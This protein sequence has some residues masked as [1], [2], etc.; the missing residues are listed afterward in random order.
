MSEPVSSRVL[1]T[2]SDPNREFHFFRSLGILSLSWRYKK[3]TP[4]LF[5]SIAT[6]L[7]HIPVFVIFERSRANPQPCDSRAHVNATALRRPSRRTLSRQWPSFLW[8]TTHAKKEPI[9]SEINSDSLFGLSFN[10][11][12]HPVTNSLE[13]SIERACTL[14]WTHDYPRIRDEFKFVVV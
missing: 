8:D 6:S 4:S 14:E 13:S 2:E 10:F 12:F 11:M 3:K 5:W 1:V 9:F 7:T